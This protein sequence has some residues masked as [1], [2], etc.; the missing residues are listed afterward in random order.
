MEEKSLVVCLLVLFL[1]IAFYKLATSSET[2]RLDNYD[3]IIGK[4][5]TTDSCVIVFNENVG[6]RFGHFL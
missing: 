1:A 3:F 6:D 4:W 2:K 5:K